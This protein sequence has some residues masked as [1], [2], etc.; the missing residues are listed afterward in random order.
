MRDSHQRDIRVSVGLRI[1]QL[2]LRLGI[3]QEELALRARLDRTYVSAVENGK[4]N[5]S[6]LNIQKLAGSLQVSMSE[7]FSSE[8][9]RIPL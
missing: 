6:I 7:F 5:V 8:D 9:F 3:S 4:R 2:R 1:R